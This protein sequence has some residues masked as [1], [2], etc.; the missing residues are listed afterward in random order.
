MDPFRNYR[1]AVAAI[2]RH[3][4]FGQCAVC[5]SQP[6]LV[7]REFDDL[8]RRSWSSAEIESFTN[9]ARSALL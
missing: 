4:P 5:C 1:Q 9:A 8:V 7:R 2:V 6:T 3:C